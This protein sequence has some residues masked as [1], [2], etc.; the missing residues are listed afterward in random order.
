MKHEDIL[1]LIFKPIPWYLKILGFNY[2]H[3][4]RVLTDP[5]LK[6]GEW[7]YQVKIEFKIL[8][9]FNIKIKQFKPYCKSNHIV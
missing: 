2:R 9:W 1:E 6:K 3:G 8:Y 7:A 4:M 5:K